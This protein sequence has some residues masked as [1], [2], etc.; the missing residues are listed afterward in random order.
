MSAPT[1]FKPSWLLPLVALTAMAACSDPA[2]QP[3]PITFIDTPDASQDMK[4]SPTPDMRVVITDPPDMLQDLG[5]DL[6]PEDMAPPTLALADGI[7]LTKLDAY[8]SVRIP[9]M[10]GGSA[11][12]ADLPL[13]AGRDTLFRAYVTLA[14]GGP[15]PIKAQLIEQSSEQPLAERELTLTKTSSDDDRSSIIELM[16]PGDRLKPST[17]IQLRLIA[18]SPHGEQP[19]EATTPNPARWPQD[20]S[21]IAPGFTD[22]GGELTV[23]IVPFRYNY[24]GSGRLPDT[25][26]EQVGR[27]H[28]LL[29]ALYPATRV[30]LTVREPID[31]DSSPDW[32]DFNVE[33]RSLKQQDNAPGST[34]Y[35]GMISPDVDFNAYCN[36]RCTTGQSFTVRDADASSYRVG[37]GVGF[38][39]ERWAWTAAHEIGHMHGRG[40]APCDV[41]FWDRDRG[42]PHSGG[43]VGIWGWDMRQ[44]TLYAPDARTDFMGYCDDLWISDYTYK[45]LFDRLV[46]VKNLTQAR[47]LFAQK[48]YHPLSFGPTRTPKWH[49]PSLEADAHTGE[50]VTVLFW[51]KHQQLITRA[52]APLAR[53]SHDDH[54]IAF[55][56]EAPPKTFAVSFA[57]TPDKLIPIY[58]ANPKR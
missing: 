5:P 48:T 21:Y 47:A 25:S 40:H 56:P 11:V 29:S 17:T 39:G 37:T 7:T 22:I 20:G 31:W 28:A 27:I 3:D 24:D 4:G 26:A 38:T 19:V 49:K 10:E 50:S 51:D 53:L 13:I 43:D 16:V 54:Q 57:Q 6:K 34:Y 1:P 52:Q 8:Q 2:Q 46:A 42:Y 15:L 14:Q 36:G 33:L 35:Y 44:D 30:N 41:A 23:L 12:G 32:G 18:T 55:I 9:L 58:D 45:G